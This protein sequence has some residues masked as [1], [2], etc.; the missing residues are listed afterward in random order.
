MFLGG[1]QN[2]FFIRTALAEKQVF[3]V[4]LGTR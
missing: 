3:P 1:L 2:H 4:T